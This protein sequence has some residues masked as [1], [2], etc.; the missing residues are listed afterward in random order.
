LNKT[1]YLDL[2]INY[3]IPKIDPKGFLDKFVIKENNYY[4]PIDK[5][6][7]NFV[8]WYYNLYKRIGQTIKE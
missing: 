8:K 7:Y 5:K 3:Y 6:L 1:I 4:M 2:A